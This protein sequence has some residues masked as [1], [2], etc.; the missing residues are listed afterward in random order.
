MFNEFVSGGWNTDLLPNFSSLYPFNELSE[1]VQ[2][3][4]PMISKFFSVTSDEI[5]KANP[6]IRK[7]SINGL[8]Q[9]KGRYS[10]RVN[11]FKYMFLAMST[12]TLEETLAFYAEIESIS[13]KNL[14]HNVI[15]FENI[16]KYSDDISKASARFHN[17]QNIIRSVFIDNNI[18]MNDVLLN[19]QNKIYII[20]HNYSKNKNFNIHMRRAMYSIQDCIADNM[21]LRVYF[22][23]LNDSMKRSENFTHIYM[24]DYNNG[25]FEYHEEPNSLNV[26]N[27]YYDFVRDNYSISL[28]DWNN[29]T[30]NTSNNTLEMEA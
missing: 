23:I 20:L 27:F 28:E 14:S 19:Q 1:E 25:T 21:D 3:E 17:L 11:Q 6:N 18:P 4:Y 10:S 9:M 2:N 29:L 12:F 30:N 7:S 22:N 15:S 16:V 13:V 26:N 8:V 5:V 24:W